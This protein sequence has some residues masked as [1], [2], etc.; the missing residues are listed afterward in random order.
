MTRI[1]K[2]LFLSFVPYISVLIGLYV[3]SNAWIALILYHLAILM[4]IIIHFNEID[5]IRFSIQNKTIFIL[6]MISTILVFP[7]LYFFWDQI[8]IPDPELSQIL[9]QFHLTGVSFLLFMIY[10]SSVHPVLEEIYWRFIISFKS[11]RKFNF[12]FDAL[13]AGY[14][15]LV[16]TY[17][18]KWPL[19]ILSFVLLLGTAITW[20]M[21]KE[22]YQDHLTLFVSHA[23]ADFSIMTA[24]LLLSQR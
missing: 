1:R 22:K 7:V 6:G 24:I 9:N 21:I 18:V 10:L 11:K 20:R 14:H 13:F 2:L 16:L 4:M 15:I 3:L 8:K 23:L 19:I 5:K 12:L 17:F